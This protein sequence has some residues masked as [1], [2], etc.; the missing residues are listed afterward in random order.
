MLIMRLST[1][2]ALLLFILFQGVASIGRSQAISM[3]LRETAL[4]DAI[5]HIRKQSGYDFILDKQLLRQ[6]H[7]VSLELRDAS[8][9]QALQQVFAGQSLTYEIRESAKLVVVKEVGDRTNFPNRHPKR[10][11][12]ESNGSLLILA[13]P[14]CR[15]KVVDSLGNPLSGASVRVLDA[16]GKRTSLQTQ[17]DRNGE[18]VLRNVPEDATL[19]ISYIGYVAQAL[20]VAANM[21]AIVLKV[22]PSA[23]D[24]VEINAGYWTVNKREATGNISRVT[25]EE[26]QTQPVSNPMAALQGRMAGVHITEDSGLPGS[27]YRVQIRGRNSLRAEANDPLYVIDGVPYTANTLLQ[28]NPT[29][30]LRLPS[31]MSIIN[32]ADIASVEV[33]K[34]ADATAIYG[35][36]GANG[37][38]LITT[39]K[40][41]AGKTQVDVNLSSGTG[42]VANKVQLLDTEQYLEMRN[43]AF[44]NDN[45]IP[46][47]TDY[48]VNGT[49]DQTRY[50]DWQEELIGST[51][52]YTNAQLSVSGGNA[53][54]R[55]LFGGGYNRQTTVFPGDMNYQ[56]GSGQFNLNH[57]SENRKFSFNVTASFGSENN[58]MVDAQ[59]A[60]VMYRLPPNAPALYDAAGN[61][62]WENG[63]WVN[64]LA[65]LEKDYEARTTNLITNAVLGYEVIPGL[66]LKASFGYNAMQVREVR[67][68]PISAQNP[69]TS[70]ALTGSASFASS[71][72][73]NWIVEP[74]A[75][76]QKAIGGGLLTALLGT[77]FQENTDE[78]ART[79]T[80][81]VDND[82]LLRSVAAAPLNGTTVTN[83][84]AQYRYTA[85]FGRINY[86][87][88]EKYIVNFTARRDGSSRFG[89]DRQF[90]NF[91][92]V[93]AAW[94]FSNEEG[95]KNSLP[96]LSF[97]KLR[98]SFGTTGSDQIG[99]YG[100]L[101]S[102]SS[103]TRQ[104]MGTGLSPSR[105]A[106][107]EYGW[108]S[109]EKMEG[110]LE[111]G[112]V[113]DRVTLSTSWYRNRS[114]NQLVGLPLPGTTG[115]TSVQ[116]NLPATVQ[117]TGWEFDLQTINIRSNHFSWNS[118]FNLSIP[119]NKL[120]AY[121]NLETS[122]HANTYRVGEPLN[123]SLR[124]S[125]LGVNP[126]T[127]IYQFED[128]DGNSS[129][130]AVGDR[131]FVRHGLDYF[132]GLQN[133]FSYKGLQLDIFLQFTKTN[134][135]SYRSEFLTPGVL[136]N[137]PL[138]VLGRWEVPGDDV[139]IQ[140]YRSL[141][142]G[143][144]NAAH[145]N[146]LTSDAALEDAS[147][148]R[149]KNVSLSWGLPAFLNKKARLQDSRILLQGQNL[150]TITNFRG[151]DPESASGSVPAL[152]TITAG[153][154]FTF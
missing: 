12:A 40:G 71:T 50:T 36:R 87:L 15:G 120:I 28:A 4:Y 109:N 149:I 98:G 39:K 70:I 38:I 42:R 25:A 82:E 69:L 64:P 101:D 66:L 133:A 106:N 103:T 100:Y 147:F 113:Q 88:A 92:A 5:R 127:G 58:N 10:S 81:G 68:S 67:I 23:L 17:T 21:G 83:S 74:Q 89:P 27:G 135:T 26:I 144:I 14:E 33:L 47:A 96:W 91:A 73:G 142:S 116:F 114:S 63:T 32:P 122:T 115:F 129:I 112:F 154:Q 30:A 79:N 78:R 61:L 75:Q 99:N 90:G 134:R 31:P 2:V 132:G 45:R 152:R 49:W 94:V 16:E 119:R 124:Y 131:K 102:Y 143:V 18:F 76:Y 126:E 59:M 8:L 11:A 107:S 137:Q 141:A 97:G 51:A 140:R 145:N 60:M 54:T 95:I 1:T 29:T 3:S 65:D 22:S 46:T 52:N 86:S 139:I 56:R 111:L 130:T 84:Y 55:F 108:E 13:F 37:V 93:G 136:G 153:I 150:L 72:G 7:P 148:I 43:E 44:A 121:P 34:D 138:E 80:T 77:T 62:N 151:I 146:W 35:S 117:N 9:E 20:R 125:Y 6:S 105:L 118:S 24:E 19:E 123:V 57:T 53:N 85:I 104:Y 128:L 48:D 41:V 110:A